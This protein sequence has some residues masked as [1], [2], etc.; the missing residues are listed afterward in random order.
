MTTLIYASPKTISFSPI[1]SP[2][3][4]IRSLNDLVIVVASFLKESRG[5]TGFKMIYNSSLHSSLVTNSAERPIE[6]NSCIKSFNFW[7]SNFS[8]IYASSTI[9]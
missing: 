8:L 6:L 3:G 7:V 2:V 1:L 5:V 4:A 9:R